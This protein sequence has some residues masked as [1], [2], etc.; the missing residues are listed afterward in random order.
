MSVQ[1]IECLRAETEPRRQPAA[2][3]SSYPSVANPSDHVSKIGSVICRRTPC[4]SSS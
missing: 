1:V 4:S 3:G 2:I